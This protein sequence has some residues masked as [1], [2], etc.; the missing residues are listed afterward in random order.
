M[1]VFNK[2]L[3]LLPGRPLLVGEVI[4]HN[5]DGTSAIELPGNIVIWVDGQTVAVGLK[6]FVQD[7][8]VQG[9]APDLPVLQ[10]L[11]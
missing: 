7:G 1:N 8:R 10:A 11:I 3:A 4:A 5:A 9:Q 2:F 6:A